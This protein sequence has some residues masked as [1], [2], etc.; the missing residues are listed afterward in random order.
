MNYRLQKK[1]LVIVSDILS[2]NLS[3]LFAYSLRFDQF[4]FF[5]DSIS[6]YLSFII[7]TFIFIFIFTT[8]QIY[9]TYF[10]YFNLFS[11]F[12][13][14]KRLIIYLVLFS[15]IILFFE[16]SIPRSIGIL[17]SLI[18]FMMIITSRIFAI[19]ILQNTSKDNK[20]NV[21]IYGA[22]SGGIEVANNI[23]LNQRFNILAFIDDDLNKIGRKLD[24]IKIYDIN[25]ISKII[26]RKKVDNILIAIPSLGLTGRRRLIE[27]LNVYNIKVKLL[28]DISQL[29]LGT[30][31]VN[32]F[33]HVE[34]SDILNRKLDINFNNIKSTLTGKNILITGGGGS[35][36]SELAKQIILAKPNK[37][38]IIDSSELN[39][40]LVQKSLQELC[41]IHN[42]ITKIEFYILNITER[43]KLTKIIVKINPDIIYHSAAYKHVNILELEENI[44]EAARNNIL[45]TYN[46]VKASIEANCQRLIL[47]S[48][49]KAVNP[50]SIMGASKRI[51]ELIIQ[52]FNK[53]FN[54]VMTIV[55]FGNVLN[56]S[57]SVVPLFQ[58]QINEGIDLTVT[59]AEVERYFMTIPEAVGLILQTNKLSVGGEVFVL[60]MGSPVKIIDLARKMIKL[61]GLKE[62]SSDNPD[63][64][65]AIKIIG[66]K[67]G[68]KLTEELFMGNNPT[69][70]KNKDIFKANEDALTLDRV[71]NLIDELNIA[72]N[73]NNTS[74]LIKIFENNISNYKKSS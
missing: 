63:G 57:G 28:P 26:S 15:I 21:I 9:N 32:D 12:Q 17:Q 36:G 23:K 27:K 7:S 49:D 60:N 1:L 22:G 13:I 34:I 46:V 68:E 20:K 58:K 29:I 73:E 8:S 64:D 72:I 19:L 16:G 35:I 6:E 69:S 54:S 11:L 62:K 59:H 40:Y 55:R 38:S 65:I 18:L 25:S 48:T 52:A 53:N 10:R 56:S 71:D 70:T 44:I 14:S 47:I 51:A 42:L 3:L 4:L 37:I 41:K 66:L 31:T 2:L 74:K 39:L 61:S 33:K 30:I 67:P 45:G 5:P 50:T 43:K 24:G